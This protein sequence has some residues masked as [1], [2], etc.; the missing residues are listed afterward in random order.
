MDDWADG[1]GKES[2][3][4]AYYERTLGADM[5][6]NFVSII[7]ESVSLAG[8]KQDGEIVLWTDYVSSTGARG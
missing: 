6:S 3:S 8:R 7:R 5:T 2:K 1:K 4:P